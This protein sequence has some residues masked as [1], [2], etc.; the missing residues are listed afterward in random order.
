MTAEEASQHYNSEQRR[1]N[2][3]CGYIRSYQN[4]IAE[5]RSERQKK[6]VLADEKRKEI[7]KN[8]NIFDSISNTTSSREELFSHLSQINSKVQDAAGNFSTMVQ[9]RLRHLILKIP[10]AKMPQMPILT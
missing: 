2:E 4:K 8:Q 1:Y 6:V 3:L 9:V 10:T 5:Y 7:Q